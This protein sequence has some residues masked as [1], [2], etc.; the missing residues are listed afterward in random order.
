MFFSI[1]RNPA[2]RYKEGARRVQGGC[3]EGEGAKKIKKKRK[4]EIIDMCMAIAMHICSSLVWPK[5]GNVE[6]PLVFKGFFE[7]SRAARTP[8]EEERN[9]EPDR[10]GGGRGRVNLPPCGL[11]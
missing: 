9:C 4:N 6:K 3:N 8:Q 1:V 5:S 7:G 11:V 10:L 2:T